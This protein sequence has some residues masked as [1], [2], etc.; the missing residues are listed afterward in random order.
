MK[1]ERNQNKKI[2]KKE[3]IKIKEGEREED[4]K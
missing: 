3:E 1:K 4:L 2:K